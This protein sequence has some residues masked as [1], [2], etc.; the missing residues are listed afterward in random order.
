MAEIKEE[1]E[2]VKEIIEDQS[3][4]V[5][6]IFVKM[7]IVGLLHRAFDEGEKGVKEEEN[8]GKWEEGVRRWIEGILRQE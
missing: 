3:E 2:T 1:F 5:L 7:E 4:E 8:E 6:P